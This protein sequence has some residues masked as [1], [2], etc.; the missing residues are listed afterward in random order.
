[1]NECTEHSSEHKERRARNKTKER[2]L[3]KSS[4]RNEMNYERQ[5]QE[6]TSKDDIH[7][8]QGLHEA[9]QISKATENPEAM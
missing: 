7:K 8:N 6:C 5:M 9:G 4:A 1:M 2:N 3:P